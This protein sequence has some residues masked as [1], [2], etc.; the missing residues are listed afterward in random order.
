[1]ALT[2]TFLPT[3]V[4]VAVAITKL[5][6]FRWAVWGGSWMTVLATGLLI[7]LGKTTATVAWIF[8]FMICS[9]GHGLLLSSLNFAVQAIASS[10]DVAYAAAMYAFLRTVGMALSVAIGGTVFQNVLAQSSRMLDYP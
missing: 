9:L 10:P 6:R 3:S 4:I 7:L 8:M 5:G 2:I 1:M